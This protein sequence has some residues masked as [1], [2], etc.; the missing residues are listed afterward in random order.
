[1]KPL[2]TFAFLLCG[3]CAMAQ[4]NGPAPYKKNPGLPPLQLLQVDS[5]TLGKKDLKKNLG[6]IIMY[7]SPTCTHCIHQTEDIIRQINDFQKI[8]IV[9]ATYEPFN[10][11]TE[12]YKK[13]N[14]AKYPNIKLGRDTKFLLP[15]Y[16][17]IKSFPFFALYDKSGKFITVIDESNVPVEKLLKPFKK[18]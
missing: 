11:M 6:T 12:F 15:P 14:L 8:Q 9:M 13:Y 18:A 7:F 17:R 10:D 2:I 5:S 16:Y 4:K 3:I 1:M